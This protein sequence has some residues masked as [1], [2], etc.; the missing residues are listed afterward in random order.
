MNLAGSLIAFS[1][2]MNVPMCGFSQIREVCGYIIEMEIWQCR[3]STQLTSE[4]AI[5]AILSESKLFDSLKSFR[6][7][8][9]L[10]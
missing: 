4:L 1:S 8:N 6:P 5:M 3:L 7:P 2:K 10:K 9:M